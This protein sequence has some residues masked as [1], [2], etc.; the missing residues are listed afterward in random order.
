MEF[1]VVEKVEQHTIIS[2]DEVVFVYYV[3]MF[4]DYSISSVYFYEEVLT[5]ITE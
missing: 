2:K 1:G 3:R 5:K 4:K